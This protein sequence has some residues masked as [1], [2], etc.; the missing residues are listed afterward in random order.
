MLCRLVHPTC[1]GSKALGEEE[2]APVHQVTSRASRRSGGT[3]VT[4]RSAWGAR[5]RNLWNWKQKRASA[6]GLA[7]PWTDEALKEKEWRT[8][9]NSAKKRI[10]K[11][12]LGS[13]KMPED[14]TATSD[15]LSHRNLTRLEDH[16]GPHKYTATTMGMSSLYA[17]DRGSWDADHGPQSLWCRKMAPWPRVLASSQETWKLG[18]GAQSGIRKKLSPSHLWKRSKGNPWFRRMGWSSRLKVHNRLIMRRRNVRH[19]GGGQ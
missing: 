15:S 8:A 16:W 18:R 1:R 6:T 3:G 10:R 5:C 19:N 13:R 9:I 12:N 7:L 2:M 11:I 14:R 17:I 4:A